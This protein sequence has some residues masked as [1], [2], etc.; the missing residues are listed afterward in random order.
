MLPQS[1]LV[2]SPSHN[3][4]LPYPQITKLLI[5]AARACL[6]GAQVYNLLTKGNSKAIIKQLIGFWARTRALKSYG[7][8][9]AMSKPPCVF[10][11]FVA[12]VP[13]GVRPSHL[14]QK[15]PPLQ[16]LA[17]NVRQIESALTYLGS[18]SPS[19]TNI[20]LMTRWQYG[21]CCR[22]ARY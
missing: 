4:T 22:G 9:E 18:P 12:W 15:T 6:K 10:A 14:C 1:A 3:S 2:C 5:C 20:R 7:R 21:R 8:C 19:M 11:I 13:S 17:R 16:P